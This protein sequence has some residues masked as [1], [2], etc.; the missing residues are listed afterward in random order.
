MHIEVLCKIDESAADTLTNLQ[1]EMEHLKENRWLFREEIYSE[2]RE[3]MENNKFIK[4]KIHGPA[5]RSGFNAWQMEI[6]LPLLSRATDTA[7]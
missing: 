1:T 3:K 2:G 5:E 6:E 4:L 7:A